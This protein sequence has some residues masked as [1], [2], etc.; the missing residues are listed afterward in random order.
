MMHI[1]NIDTFIIFAYQRKCNVFITLQKY[2]YSI[3]Q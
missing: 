1:D 2:I 3:D